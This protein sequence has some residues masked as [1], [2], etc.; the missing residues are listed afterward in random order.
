[1]CGVLT[2]HIWPMVLAKGTAMAITVSVDTVGAQC[3]CGRV[4]RDSHHLTNHLY[5]SQRAFS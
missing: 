4:T 2:P 1:M 5:V 3:G